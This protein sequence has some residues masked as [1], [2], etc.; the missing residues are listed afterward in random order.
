MTNPGPMRILAGLTFSTLLFAQGEADPLRYVP[1]DADVVIRTVGP[2]AWQRDFAGTNLG[3]AF[4]DP[5]MLPVWTKV[6]AYFETQMMFEGGKEQVDEARSIWDALQGYQGEI[7]FAA[8]GDWEAMAGSDDLMGAAVLAFG[9]DGVSDLD[10][11]AETL[12][13]YLPGDEDGEASFAGLPAPRRE[14]DG[15]QIL[16]P[17]VHEDHVVLLFGYELEQ[18]QQWFVESSADPAELQRLRKSSIGLH[19]RLAPVFRK[20]AQ[21]AEETGGP[22][23]FFEELGMNSVRDFGVTIAPDGQY[24]RQEMHLRFQPGFRGLISAF[25]PESSRQPTLLRYLPA[26]AGTYAAAPMDMS[27]VTR[28]YESFWENYG[29]MAPMDRDEVESMFSDMTNLDLFQDVIAHIGDEYLRIDDMTALVDFDDEDEPE[30]V[31]KAKDR[32]SEA[33]YVIKLKDGKALGKNIDTAIRARGLHVGRKREDYNGQNIYRMNLLGMFPLEYAVTDSLLLVGIGQGEVTKKN[34]RLVLDAVAGGD[35]AAEPAFGPEV[36][37]RMDGM[38]AGWGGIQVGSLTE[39]LEGI[40]GIGQSVEILLADVD[41]T[42]EDVEDPWQ[43]IMDG[44]TALQAVLR[45]HKA[46][47]VVNLDYFEKDRYVMRSRW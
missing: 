4:A 36:A 17:L 3:K 37:R 27:A 6:L 29:E 9:A 11:M 25:C 40:I 14:A 5:Q 32:L 10:K 2:A 12:G 47:T 7:V 46:D 1:K 41:M 30:Q 13:R 45:R 39:T 44:C 26:S 22:A 8:R 23:E 42:L 31:T 19:V 15:M 18:R 38:R 43:L 20:L 35:G 16:G 24:V 21:V 28:V 33:C 34:L